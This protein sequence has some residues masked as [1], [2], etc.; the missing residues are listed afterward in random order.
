[1][2]NALFTV[3]AHMPII[4]A[5]LVTW[6][7]LITFALVPK[8]LTPFE[9]TF[10]FFINT[11]FEL[12]G[13]SILH[14]NLQFIQVTPG[15]ANALADLMFRLI[16]LPL[17]LVATTN[18]LLSSRTLFKWTGVVLIICFSVL[19]QQ[20]LVWAGILTLHH[21]NVFYSGIVLCGNI[22]FSSLMAWLIRRA[23]RKE[24]PSS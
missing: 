8:R 3:G 19:V 23:T 1:M 10:L 15:V 16:E 7:A 5:L 20:I 12:S 22:A 13:F 2:A 21:W 11:I 9:M 24:V 6:V 14:I 18:I 17:F 4:F